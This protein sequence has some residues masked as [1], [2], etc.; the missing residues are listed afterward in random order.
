MLALTHHAIIQFAAFKAK[1]GSIGDRLVWFSNYCILGDDI[2]IGDRRVADYY[3][4]FMTC[5][6]QVNINISK[7]VISSNGTGEFAK[8]ICRKSQDLSPLSLKEFES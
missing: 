4:Y 2:I 3:F 7:S 6:L 1:G 8:R 5:I